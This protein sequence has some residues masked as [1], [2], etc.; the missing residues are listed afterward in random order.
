V[1]IRRRL[2]LG[3]THYRDSRTSS[4][5]ALSNAEIYPARTSG[6]EDGDSCRGTS[7]TAASSADGGY[8]STLVVT[9]KYV[10]G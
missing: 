6:N 4:R 7:E 1:T 2:V 10:L 8:F 9:G 3:P 5:E